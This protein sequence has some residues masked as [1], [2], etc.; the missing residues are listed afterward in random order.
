MPQYLPLTETV[1]QS[2]KKEDIVI[3]AALNWGL[4][5]ASRCAI[6]IE[7]LQKLAGKVILCSDGIAGQLLQ[8]EF[9]SLVYYEIKSPAIRYDSNSMIINGLKQ[10]NR[11]VKHLKVD[12]QMAHNIV[13]KERATVIISDNRFGFR[14]S[15]CTNIYLTHQLSIQAG[16]LSPMISAW[17]RNIIKK[18]DHCWVP[19]F[20]NDEYCIAGDL[21]RNKFLT[22]VLYIG[23]LSRIRR[24]NLD[25]SI[26]LL[27]ILSGPEPQRTNLEQVLINK[28]SKSNLI[29]RLI[30]GTN[31][32][33]KLR[34][35]SNWDVIDLASTAQVEQSLNISHRVIT[36]SGYST[37]MDLTMIDTKVILIPTPGQGE[38]EYLAKYHANRCRTINQ[39]NLE[40]ADLA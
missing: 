6:L 15:R 24:L 4:G 32:P 31:L 27:I 13:A 23:P 22:N 2:I 12:R 7:I 33:L 14:D 19:D 34:P 11:L 16:F 25:K 5:H 26:D 37:L 36:R 30:R 20:E 9:P 1:R 3:V 17:H 29:I 38:Q 40:T 10:I 18:F 21:S 28:L 35:P 8:K 39:S